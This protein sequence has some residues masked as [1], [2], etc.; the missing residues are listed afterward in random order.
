MSDKHF[1][2]YSMCLGMIAVTDEKELEKTRNAFLS[3]CLDYCFAPSVRVFGVALCRCA[4]GVCV[5]H[6]S[7]A[8]TKW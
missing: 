5:C 8:M 4:A 7:D 6:F 3:L 2:T 1:Q